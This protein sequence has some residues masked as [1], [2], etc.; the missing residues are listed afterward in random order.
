V[1]TERE[2]VVEEEQVFEMVT[3]TG[4]PLEGGIDPESELDP[5]NWVEVSD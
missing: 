3:V 1:V 4:K 2:L 5:E